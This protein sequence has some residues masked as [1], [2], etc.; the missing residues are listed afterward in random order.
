MR[1][2]LCNLILLPIVLTVASGSLDAGDWPMFRADAARTGYC[3]EPLPEKLELLWVHRSRTAP[4]PAWPDSARITYDFAYQP[5][6]VGDSVIFGSSSEDKVVA[7]DA[8]SGR[9]LWTFF[10]GGP[11]RFAPAAWR[12][13]IFVA[14]DDG[15]L[16]AIRVRDGTLIWRRRGGPNGRMCLG[17]ERMISRWP[18]RGGPVVTDD[19]VYY[20]AGIWPS[21]GVFLHALDAR[22]GEALWTNDNAGRMHMPQPHGGANARSGVAPQGY[23]LATDER[24]FVPTGRAVPAAFRRSDGKFEYYRLQQNGSI[25]GA[26]ALVGD[27]F[28]INAGCFLERATGNLAARLGRGVF[29]VL[30]DGILRS[31]GETLVMYRWADMEGRDRRGNLVQYR[32][33][34][35]RR[36]VALDN[37]S[38]ESKRAEK[39]V[40]KLPA[41]GNLYRTQ[42]RFR[43]VDENVPKQTG[44]ERTVSQ[45]RPDVEALGGEVGPFLATTYERRCEVIA[46][47]RE[48]VCGGP[49]AVRVVNLDDGRLRWSH[50][51]EGNA[52]GLAAAN[53]LL[54][55]STSKGVIYCFGRPQ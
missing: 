27:R 46:A 37:K 32:G 29:G 17:N 39:I 8:S 31:T 49:G 25:G 1:H 50:D 14:S 18:A 41:L 20:A 40:E 28:I 48:A 5:I 22:T 36:Q 43:Q 7:I 19:I 55:V 13:R 52:V 24:L 38:A 3:T 6:I 54:V 4:M 33:L 2:R 15:Y 10:T 21:D 23:L 12:D 11:V 53:G 45:S 44:L 9:L 34:E 26:R 42:V 16:Y 30:P 47:A 51:V 35:E